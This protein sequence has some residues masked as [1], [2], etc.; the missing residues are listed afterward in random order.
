MSQ[1]QVEMVSRYFFKV[2][3][4]KFQIYAKT[5]EQILE[6]TGNATANFLPVLG[7]KSIEMAIGQMEE[8]LE[9]LKNLRVDYEKEPNLQS[10]MSPRLNDSMLIHRNR[11]ARTSKS[12]LALYRTS[13]EIARFSRGS[14]D[15][16]ENENL[17]MSKIRSI[18]EETSI[19]DPTLCMDETTVSLLN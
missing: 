4:L 13:P 18:T 1:E 2:T 11:L 14:P 3:W 10:C 6:M 17:S 9:M 8:Y 19:L 7:V 5:I 16:I 15:D 12:R